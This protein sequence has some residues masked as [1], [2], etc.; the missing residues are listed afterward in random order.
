MSEPID[1]ELVKLRA[2]VRGWVF[3]RPDDDT[4]GVQCKYG[5]WIVY[6][7]GRLPRRE[8]PWGNFSAH[9]R[10]E[11]TLTAPRWT[12]DRLLSEPP[13]GWVYEARHERLMWQG[14]DGDSLCLSVSWCHDVDGWLEWDF[15]LATER[16]HHDLAAFA[17]QLKAAA[18]LAL[19]LAEIQP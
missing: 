14:D 19:I 12:L 13:E 18:E 4:V 10:I 3:E 2:T 1:L 16:H 11:A 17:G 7:T 5:G 6:Q 9:K 8:H 15:N